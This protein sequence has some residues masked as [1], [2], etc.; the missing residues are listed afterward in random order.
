[1]QKIKAILFD[2][3]GVILDTDNSYRLLVSNLLTNE[4][5]YSISHQECIER[6]RGK[7]ADQ[8]ARELFFEGVDFADEFIKKIHKLSEDYKIDDSI[9]VPNL[10]DLLNST[11]IPKII[12]SN[13]R[14]V[15]ILSNLKDVHLENYFTHV[16]GRD[17]LKVMKP[18]PQVYLKGAEALG[19]DIKDCLVVEDSAT[20]LKAGVD[21]GAITVAFTGTG[22][23]VEELAKLNPNYIVSDLADIINIIKNN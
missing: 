10:L 5:N 2:C 19:L 16:L 22:G 7:N 6:W 18:D 20:G 21:A 8:I 11:D 3:D 9:I 12:C 23:N 4:F 14:S 1:M 15:R 13:G 17:I